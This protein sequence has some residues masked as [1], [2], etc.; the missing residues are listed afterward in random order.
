MRTAAADTYFSTEF[1]GFRRLEASDKLR[2]KAFLDLP[3]RG[4]SGD[5]S[6]CDQVVT[7][8]SDY[9]LAVMIAAETRRPFKTDGGHLGVGPRFAEISDIIC[10]FHGATVPFVLRPASDGR[11]TLLGEAYVD[12]IMDGQFMETVGPAETF[13]LF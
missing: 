11:W 8:S 3:L 9:L 5:I 2:Y 7:G 10:I 1:G 13:V 12:G 4:H 6:H